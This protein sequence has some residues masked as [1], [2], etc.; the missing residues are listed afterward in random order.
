MDG[1]YTMFGKIIK[2][3]DVAITINNQPKNSNDH[4]NTNIPMTMTVLEKP[5]D[6]LKTEFN[7][8]P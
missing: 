7:F 2:G 5:L 4:P 1:E 3:M 6:E 8:V